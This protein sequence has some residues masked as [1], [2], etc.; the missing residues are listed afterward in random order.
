MHSFV[1]TKK[2]NC[3]SHFKIFRFKPSTLP[4]ACLIASTGILYISAIFSIFC[5]YF[6]FSYFNVFSFHDCFKVKLIRTRFSAS[7]FICS[8]NFSSF[9]LRID[10]KVQGSFLV[11]KRCSNS[12]NIR[13][14][15]VSI[16]A[17]GIS[18]SAFSAAFSTT[19]S[20]T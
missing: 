10:S 7:S 4:R 2:F 20:R 6:F 16:I 8:L 13:S 3:F 14:T 15:S 11:C 9:D 19:S 12:R 1:F 5:S 18:I 17:S